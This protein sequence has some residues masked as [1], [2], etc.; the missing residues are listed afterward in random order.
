MNQ[1]LGDAPPAGNTFHDYNPRPLQASHEKQGSTSSKPINKSSH[2]KPFSNT[3]TKSKGQTPNISAFEQQN[4]NSQ[5][6]NQVDPDII[7]PTISSFV[8]TLN[9]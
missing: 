7:E 2:R 4:M 6:N 1:Q 9:R 8:D 5:D 3:S